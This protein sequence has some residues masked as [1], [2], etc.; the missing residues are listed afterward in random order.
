MGILD[1]GKKSIQIIVGVSAYDC[2]STGAD[3]ARVGSGF[4]HS[5]IP[6]MRYCWMCTSSGQR[7][8]EEG[9]GSRTFSLPYFLNPFSHVLAASGEQT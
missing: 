5:V 2:V 3:S 1:G 7:A 6:V 8:L 4:C 9:W